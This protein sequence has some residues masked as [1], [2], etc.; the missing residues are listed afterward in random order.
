[1]RKYD[2][3]LFQRSAVFS[4]TFFKLRFCM[5]LQYRAAALA[6]VATQF[7]WGFMEIII[8]SSFYRT[9]ADAFPMTMQA[10]ASYIWLQQSFLMLFMTWLVESEIMDAIQNG[11]V[12]YELC[13]PID[14]YQM[15]FSRT[16][17]NRLSAA[18][19]RCLPILVVAFFIPAPYGLVLPPDVGTFLLFLLTICLGFLVT[20]SLCM[21]VYVLTFFTLSPKGLQIVSVTLIDFL[22]GGVIP[23]PF[24][25]DG[26][27][28]LMELLP[29]GSMQN[30]PF[31][32]YSGDIAGGE[33]MEAVLIQI[34]WFV[35]ITVLGKVLCGIAIRQVRVQGG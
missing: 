32:V 17:A 4:R 28:R 9:G 8:Y 11:G 7:A 30:V 21:L 34:F 10:T 22:S 19:L 27:R 14:L 35:V 3:N 15:W 23:I 26:I 13:R 12:A 5:G 1:M 31:R 24:F 16:I 18:L 33:C 20:V 2:R 29:F 6:G 25:P